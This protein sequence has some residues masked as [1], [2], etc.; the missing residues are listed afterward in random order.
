M[1]RKARRKSETGIYHIIMRGVNKQHIFQDR[2]D[3]KRFLE[4]MMYYKDVSKY[5]VYGYCLMD[6]HIH[7]LIK[8]LGE[9]ISEIVKRT[10]SS[11]VY[12]YNQKYDRCGHLFQERYRSE[13]VEADS[14]FL[15]VLR[16]IHQNPVKAG[17]A[18][19][20]K[21]YLWSSYIEYIGNPFYTDV[22]YALRMFSPDKLKA[23]SLF[24]Q[25]MNEDNQDK[26]LKSNVKTLILD[27]EVVSYFHNLGIRNINELQILDKEKRNEIIRDIKKIEGITIRQLSRVTGI[28]KSVIDRV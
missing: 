19:D 17:M 12:R 7:L 9:S 6:N 1:P 2:E 16:Y 25:F 4:T 11:Y 10:S 14:Y 3:R 23:K 13:T 21:A 22:Y 15:S 28:S 5:E 8:E 20:M 24:Q 26:C 18:K 27:E